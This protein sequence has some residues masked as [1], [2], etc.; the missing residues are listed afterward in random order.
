MFG[1]PIWVPH[2][3]REHLPL[4]RAEIRH[5]S[6]H[7]VFGFEDNRSRWIWVGPFEEKPSECVV[8][9]M[10]STGVL[11]NPVLFNLQITSA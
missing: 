9:W 6:N 5:V 1:S 4:Q 10:N 2:F 8:I 11:I 7:V 3:K